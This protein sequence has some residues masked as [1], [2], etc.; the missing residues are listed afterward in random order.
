MTEPRTLL[1]V[2]RHRSRQRDLRSRSRDH[3]PCAG[4]VIVRSA[5][6]WN[7]TGTTSHRTLEGRQNRHQHGH[8]REPSLPLPVRKFNAASAYEVIGRHR[9]STV[10]KLPVANS[11]TPA[12]G[13]THA[14]DVTAYP[15]PTR[16]FTSV[17][18]P[19]VYCSLERSRRHAGRLIQN[20]ADG[21]RACGAG[22]PTRATR[23]RGE[24]GNAGDVGD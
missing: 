16:D 5:A 23:Y 8:H 3:P 24:F 7:S 1:Q 4:G 6:E 20:P 2:G 14:D 11:C 19:Q 12:L 17:L 15:W 21:E 13:R 18:S 22:E 10:E 9:S